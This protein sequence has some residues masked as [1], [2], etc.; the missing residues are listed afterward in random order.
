MSDAIT[1]GL[2]AAVPATLVGLAAL[3]TALRAN[4]KTDSLAVSVDGRLSAL[5]AT[6]G[7]EQRLAGHVEGVEAE[8]ARN[9]QT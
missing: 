9:E 2:I 1:V 5:L 3:V 8:R 7:S 4:R 6:T